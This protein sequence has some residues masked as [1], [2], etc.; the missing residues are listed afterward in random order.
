MTALL[1]AGFQIDSG[2]L[3]CLYVDK[4]ETALKTRKANVFDRKSIYSAL[5]VIGHFYSDMNKDI[6]TRLMEKSDIDQNDKWEDYEIGL[7][8]QIF[9]NQFMQDKMM[10]NPAVKM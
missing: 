3:I 4:S 5:G 6:A 1:K 9:Y 2:I 7:M 10:Q 8:Q